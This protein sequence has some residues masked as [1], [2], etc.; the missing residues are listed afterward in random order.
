M[1]KRPRD[2]KAWFS[3]QF[4]MKIVCWGWLK[5]GHWL[6]WEGTCMT[7]CANYGVWTSSWEQCNT[8]TG[9]YIE[10]W[11]LSWLWEKD[12]IGGHECGEHGESGI[13]VRWPLES[14]SWEKCSLNRGSDSGN[15]WTL[16]LSRSV[17]KCYLL[18][19]QRILSVDQVE[20]EGPK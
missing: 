4:I 16:K 8:S 10:D 1:F 11:V 19:P 12:Q 5:I 13:S 18:S 14:Y 2:E 15:E 3:E 7:L 9:F 17:G 20:I 6:P